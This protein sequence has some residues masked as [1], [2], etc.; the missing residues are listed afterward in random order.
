MSDDDVWTEFIRL[1]S[2]WEVEAQTEED[3][4]LFLWWKNQAGMGDLDSQCTTRWVWAGMGD[5]D[6]QVGDM[7]ISVLS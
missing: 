4:N 7:V 5:L 1:T 6:S 3:G 2:E